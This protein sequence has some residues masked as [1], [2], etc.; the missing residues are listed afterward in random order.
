MAIIQLAEPFK[1]FRG[2]DEVTGGQVLYPA[3]RRNFSR[4]FVQPANPQTT[5]QDTIRTIFTALTQ[6]YSTLT[7]AEN[8]TWI[9]LAKNLVRKDADGNDIAPK[10][11]PTFIEV[12]FWNIALG[13]APP[14]TAPPYVTTPGILA[15][16]AVK[17][18]VLDTGWQ[19]TY[20]WDGDPTN[21]AL[22]NTGA[23]PG[24]RRQPRITD[25]R[26]SRQTPDTSVDAI[27]N[28]GGTITILDAASRFAIATADRI[29]QLLQ[30]IT[31]DGLPGAFFRNVPVVAAP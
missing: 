20:T 1:S 30:I 22:K 3:L 18:T 5:Y 25:Y 19:F 10:P 27:T 24:L 14:A 8:L 28:A 21:L 15:I 7:D 6:L 17:R 26:F 9:D 31:D 16:S 11:K 13:N 12:G 29:G 23:L 4:T 2:R